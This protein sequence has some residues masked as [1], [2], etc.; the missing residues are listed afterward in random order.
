MRA[1]QHGIKSD[2]AR[3]DR[4]RDEDIDY[5]DIPELEDEFFEQPLVRWPPKKKTITIRVDPISSG[6]AGFPVILRT[7]RSTTTTGT[8]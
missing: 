4:L 1:K 6:W 3:I 2:L 8:H 5:S 7:M